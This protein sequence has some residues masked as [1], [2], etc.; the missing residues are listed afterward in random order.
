MKTVSSLAVSLIVEIPHS[1]ILDAI[2]NFWTNNP[3]KDISFCHE[4]EGDIE[5][6]EEQCDYMFPELFNSRSCRKLSALFI[7]TSKDL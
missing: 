7:S 4:G 3:N 5:L 1:D 6:T 2:Q